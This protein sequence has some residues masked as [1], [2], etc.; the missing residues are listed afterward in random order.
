[1]QSRPLTLSLA[2]L[3]SSSLLS[4]H[5]SFPIALNPLSVVSQGTFVC[6]DSNL[7]HLD[8][9]VSPSAQGK[10]DWGGQGQLQSQARNFF[11]NLVELFS[12]QLKFH[13]LPKPGEGGQDRERTQREGCRRGWVADSLVKGT[14]PRSEEGHP[15]NLAHKE[16]CTSS[17]RKSL[18]A[19]SPLGSSCLV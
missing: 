2:V 7:S 4:S 6:S 16:T 19:F 17:D 3:P 8:V 9:T 12:T 15:C 11:E 5:T 14:H 10:G 13:C 18:E 1:M